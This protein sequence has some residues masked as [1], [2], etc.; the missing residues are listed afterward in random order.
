M[1]LRSRGAALLVAAACL[2]PACR[3]GPLHPRYQVADPPAPAPIPLVNEPPRI[4]FSERA[5][6]LI[7]IDGAPERRPLQGTNLLR[8]IN[9][10]AY[11]LFDDALRVYYVR[12]ARI[13]ARAPA[14]EGPWTVAVSPPETL[15]R[16]GAEA[17]AAPD[18]ETFA[19][20]AGE[21]FPSIF[22][23]TAPAELIVS[24]GRLR[25]ESIPA[26]S[27]RYA[28]NTAAG[29]FFDDATRDWYV[30]LSGRWF[31]AKPGGRWEYVSANA[32]P[33]GFARIP[34]E[35]PKA[36][37]LASVAGTSQARAAVSAS[38]VEQTETVPVGERLA[39]SYDGGAARLEPIAGTSLRYA[40]NS[41]TPIIEVDA[42]TYCALDR[43][44][45][46]TAGSAYGPWSV[47]VAVPAAIY[48]IPPSCPLHY[49]T[50]VHVRRA[51]PAAVVVGYRPGYLGTY[52]APEGVVVFGTGHRHPGYVGSSVWVGYPW[53]FG[54]GASFPLGRHASLGVSFDLG[55]GLG[56]GLGWRA[57][58]SRPWWGPYRGGGRFRHR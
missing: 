17:D 50:Y 44:I 54:F 14:L 49:V 39:V 53:T 8:V 11:V 7:L 27:L 43:G 57:G 30:L 24:D 9:T 36:W 56:L 47:A 21:P 4:I 35:H 38:S 5:A 45:W 40:V 6:A 10:R 19:L 28:A 13:W 22:V 42:R 26:T 51:T 58:Y 52:V 23:S 32:L 46:F 48:T 29:A 16:L 1:L 41:P 31:R 3:F 55:Y 37:V 20:P 18:L 2:L 15:A 34:A 12:V 33:G 25:L